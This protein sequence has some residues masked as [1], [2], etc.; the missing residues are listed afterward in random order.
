MPRTFRIAL[1]NGANREVACQVVRLNVGGSLHRFA[2]HGSDLSDYRTGLRI[3]SVWSVWGV[4]RRPRDV[5]QEL[6]NRI[7][8]KVGVEALRAELRRHETLNP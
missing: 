6:V 7:A 5:A 3:G 4:G 1:P 2:I 8:D